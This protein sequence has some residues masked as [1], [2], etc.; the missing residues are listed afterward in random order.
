MVTMLTHNENMHSRTGILVSRTA[1]TRPVQ[2]WALACGWAA[3]LLVIPSLIWRIAMLSGADTGVAEAE[4]FR[5]STTG[6]VYVL[7]LNVAEL[8]AALLCLG[9]VMPWGERV[10]NWVPGIGGRAIPRLLPVVV[11]G[12]GNLA[13]YLLLVPWGTMF[14]GT[15]LGWWEAWTPARAMNP[16]QTG[17]LLAA[18]LPFF[19]WPLAVTGAL[20]GYWQR[21]RPARV[22]GRDVMPAPE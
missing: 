12:V 5:S 7:G 10:P 17:F 9:L 8:A 18:Y 6:L 22:D 19:A 20:I 2:G 1:T 11:G 15:W 21:R 13:L 4:L 16:V 14:L 3:C